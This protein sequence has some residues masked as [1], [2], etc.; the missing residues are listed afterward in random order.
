MSRTGN[1]YDNAVMESAWGTVKTAP[2]GHPDVDEDGRL[3]WSTRQ[4]AK[5]EVFFYLEGFYNRTRRHSALG[6]L[7]PDAF[8]RHYALGA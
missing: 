5:S 7:S 1:C 3:L 2:W 6:Y 8:E 4:Q